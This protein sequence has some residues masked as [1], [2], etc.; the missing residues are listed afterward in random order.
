MTAEQTLDNR[1]AVPEHPEDTR[2]VSVDI[3]Y[4]GNVGAAAGPGVKF[5]PSVI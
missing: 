1:R 4:R 2:I 5:N 3:T